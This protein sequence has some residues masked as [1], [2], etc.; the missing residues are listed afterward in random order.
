MLH[1]KHRNGTGV[2]TGLAAGAAGGLAAS[3]LMSLAHEWINRAAG[4]APRA[5]VQSSTAQAVDEAAQRVAGRPLFTEKKYAG[6]AALH[7][8]VGTA[9]GGLYGAAAS[10]A[11]A[12]GK[13]AGVPFGT[14]VW[15]GLHLGAAPALGL[16][17]PYEAPLVVEA[18]E[19]AS[20]VVYGV[21]TEMVRRGVTAAV[22]AMKS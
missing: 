6:S 20:H 13:A 3:Y 4:G 16:A 1:R 9:V 11:P 22:R 19:L 21:A 2:W 18:A 12:L 5:G 14:A 15:A 17:R 10:T 7:Y 8:A